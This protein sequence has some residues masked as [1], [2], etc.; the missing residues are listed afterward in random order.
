MQDLEN[1]YIVITEGIQT[2]LRKH[3]CQDAYELLKKFSRNHSTISKQDIHNFINSLCIDE[4]I[5]NELQEIT[6]YNYI[7]Y[8]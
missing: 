6:V 7:G 4:T 1:N 3:G 5:K 8:C 2:V